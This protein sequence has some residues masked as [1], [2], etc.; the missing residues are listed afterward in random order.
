MELGDRTSSGCRRAYS[1]APPAAQRGVARPRRRDERA[2]AAA[3]D[4]ALRPA[5]RQGDQADSIHARYCSHGCGRPAARRRIG[6]RAWHKVRA[7]VRHSGARCEGRDRHQ[8]A[9]SERCGAS[10]AQG[11][12]HGVRKRSR[13][14]D[15]RML[16]RLHRSRSL[17][18]A[19]RWR[20]RQRSFAGAARGDGPRARGS[21]GGPRR[22]IGHDGWPRRGAARCARCSRSHRDGNPFV[23]R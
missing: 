22:A 16:V 14:H 12:A 20:G 19:R 7:A 11:A 2:R 10:R 18:R 6:S 8:R 13:H 3:R 4:A 5:G 17:R 9:R 1:P 15:G 21:R 23:C